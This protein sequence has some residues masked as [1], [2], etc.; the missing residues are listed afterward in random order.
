MIQRANQQDELL[1]LINEK[2]EVIAQ[3]Y[4][5]IVYQQK[6]NNFQIILENFIS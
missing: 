4:K 6:K 5:T 2:V 3:S 1:D